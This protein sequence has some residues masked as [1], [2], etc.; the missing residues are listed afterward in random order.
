MKHAPNIEKLRKAF[1]TIAN[2]LVYLFCALCVVML[3]FTLFAKR[4][5]DGA[6]EVF[7]YEMRIVVSASMEK[8]DRADV[9]NY[10]IKDIKTGSMVFV[11]LV[12]SGDT[13]AQ[14]FYASLKVGDVL[15]FRYV[16]AVQQETITH[17]IVDIVEKPT[18]GYVITLEGDNK[19]DSGSVSQQVIDTTEVDSP[20]YVIGKVTGKSFLFGWLIYSLKQPVGMSLLIIVPSLIIIILQVIKIVNTLNANKKKRADKEVDELKRRIAELE[21]AQQKENI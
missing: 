14:A 17:R 16:E 4:D 20:N 6:V 1:E 8:N 2:I 19:P 15:T 21:S 3:V 9:S 10:A 11:R 18:G 12:P 5:A 13:D 7:G